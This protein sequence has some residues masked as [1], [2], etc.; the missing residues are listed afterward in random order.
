MIPTV[1]RRLALWVPP[2]AYMALIYHLS[3]ESNPLPLLTETI[4]DKALHL[5]EYGTLGF[6]FCRAW[7]G[8]R[9]AWMAA[10]MCAFAATS[11]YGA[12][13]EWHQLFTPGRSSD[14]R[15]WLADTIGGGL[16]AAGYYLAASR[17]FVSTVSRRPRRRPR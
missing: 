3:S 14:V 9:V 1:M 17:L 10:V 11:L 13:D 6:L 5:L 12:T 2:L 15:D 4:W 16:G 7:A 8:E